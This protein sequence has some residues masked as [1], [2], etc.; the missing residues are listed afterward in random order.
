MDKLQTIAYDHK[1][2]PSE[3]AANATRL[4]SQDKIQ[5]LIGGVI[6]ATGMAELP[7]TQPAKESRPASGGQG[8]YH[9]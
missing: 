3:A 4:V 2:Q 8:H 1:G 7:I 6:A 9:P 5:Y